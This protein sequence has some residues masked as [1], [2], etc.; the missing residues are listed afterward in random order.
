MANFPLEKRLFE[1]VA[2]PDCASRASISRSRFSNTSDCQQQL[3]N[4]SRSA[5]L[6]VE[7]VFAQHHYL[8]YDP[9]NLPDTPKTPEKL[10]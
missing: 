2:S 1:Q 6:A 4:H 7:D 9:P 10:K 3:Q 8:A 5:K